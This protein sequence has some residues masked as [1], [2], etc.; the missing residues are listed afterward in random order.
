[1]PYLIFF[2]PHNHTA[3]MKIT[4]RESE[5]VHIWMVYMESCVIEYYKIYLW[6]ICDVKNENTPKLL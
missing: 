3:Y 4:I 5:K 2:L 1:M 6:Y